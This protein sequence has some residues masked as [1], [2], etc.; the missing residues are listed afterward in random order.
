MPLIHI[1][2]FKRRDFT[3]YPRDHSE[4][5]K[6]GV[7]ITKIKNRTHARNFK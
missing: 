5:T 2:L 6:Y 4:S 7:E 1:L 3:V